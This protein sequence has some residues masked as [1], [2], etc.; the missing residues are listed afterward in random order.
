[1]PGLREGGSDS[2]LPT[3]YTLA[4]GSANATTASPRFVCSLP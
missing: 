4:Y 2:R 1:M 3:R